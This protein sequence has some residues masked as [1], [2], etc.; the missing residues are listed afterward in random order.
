VNYR[1]AVTATIGLVLIPAS[2]IGF[3]VI[4]LAIAGTWAWNQV[5]A[6]N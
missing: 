1:I 2:L 5:V 6:I 3:E 4:V